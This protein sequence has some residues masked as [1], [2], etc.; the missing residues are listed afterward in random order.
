MGHLL[1]SNVHLAIE[2]SIRKLAKKIG[3]PILK[4]SRSEGFRYKNLD[5]LLADENIINVLGEIFLM[6]IFVAFIGILL[7][8][9][10]RRG[11]TC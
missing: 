7:R 11:K 5:N 2:A 1:W 6:S 10:R 9:Y 4:P 8:N 3:A